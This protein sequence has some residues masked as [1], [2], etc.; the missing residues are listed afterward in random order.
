MQ[1]LLLAD[2][3]YV[4]AERNQK[5]VTI[6]NGRRPIQ[7]E[8]LRLR[9]TESGLAI[10]REV[11]RVSYCLMGNVSEDILRSDGFR[12]ADDA[13]DKMRGFYPDIT[14]LSEVTVIEWLPLLAERGTG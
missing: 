6:R 3:L 5:L 8:L 2:D 7:L 13:L 11:I 10:E 9:A 12:D 4:L 1:E 14:A